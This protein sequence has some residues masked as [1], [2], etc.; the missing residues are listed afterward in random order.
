[1]DATGRRP[2][3]SGLEPARSDARHVHEAV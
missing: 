1:M 2:K 3:L